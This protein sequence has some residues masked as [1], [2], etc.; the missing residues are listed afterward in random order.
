MRD[1]LLERRFIEIHSPKLIAAASKSGADV[2]E[3]DYTADL[4]TSS[5]PRF[6]EQ[7]AAQALPG[8]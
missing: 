2:F 3:V 7:I 8:F 4:H 6:Y 5:S 1:Y